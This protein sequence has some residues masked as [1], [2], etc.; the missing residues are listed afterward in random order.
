MDKCD[1]TLGDYIQ[2]LRHLIIS[3]P[4]IYIR[5]MFIIFFQILYIYRRILDYIPFFI[6]GDFSPSNI[7]YVK[8]KGIISYPLNGNSIN[9]NLEE[10]DNN[11][12]IF[13]DYGMYA[14][15]DI[16][17]KCRPLEVDKIVS[18]KRDIGTIFHSLFLNT[19]LLYIMIQNRAK[20]ELIFEMMYLI[21]YRNRYDIDLMMVEY[22]T[23]FK[24]NNDE[25][26][27]NIK[28][29]LLMILPE[30]TEIIQ[31]NDIDKQLLN[32]LLSLIA[33]LI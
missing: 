11:N 27:M 16:L 18:I 6:H 20:Y 23:A 19:N 1:G 26:V 17:N 4:A 8:K 25:L 3:E 14:S 13:I 7:L 15:N 10:I 28:E 21:S 33:P 32:E 22:D 29:N 30:G 5:K 31:N 9:I 24:S 2:T 12:I